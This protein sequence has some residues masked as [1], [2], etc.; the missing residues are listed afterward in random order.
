MIEIRPYKKS[1]QEQLNQLAIKA[2]EQFQ[3]QYSDWNA[4]QTAVGKMS[5]LQETS[6]I[7]IAEE[8][9]NIIG[10]VAIVLPKNGSKEYFDPTWASIR[11]LIVNPEQRKKGIGKKLT[12]EC[13]KKAQLMGCKFI[14][15]HTS[16]IMEVALSMYL[17]MGFSKVKEINPIFGVEYAVYKLQI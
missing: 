14:A 12:E 7:I 5:N 1:D 15:L 9:G 2:F 10:G 6:E 4:L 17:K 8:E 13:I 16:P 3:N 11:M